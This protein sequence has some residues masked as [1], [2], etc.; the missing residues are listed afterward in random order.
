MVRHKIRLVHVV[1]LPFV[2]RV[3]HFGPRAIGVPQP[4]PPYS[5]VIY[6]FSLF[7]SFFLSLKGQVAWNSGQLDLVVGSTSHG[8]GLDLDDL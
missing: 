6:I 2:N 3:R 1:M 5:C 7:H 4:S 8:R